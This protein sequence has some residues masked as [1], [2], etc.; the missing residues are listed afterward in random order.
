MIQPEGD[1]QKRLAALAATARAAS[2]ARTA[3]PVE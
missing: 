1:P 2:T 3:A